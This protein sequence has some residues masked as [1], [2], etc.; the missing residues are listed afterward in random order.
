[1]KLPIVLKIKED[2]ILYSYLLR[3]SQ[4]NG[5]N[6]L[7]DF[8]G[9]TKILPLY[10][11]PKNAYRIVRYDIHNDLYPLLE[12]TEVSPTG[13]AELYR[14]TSLF[15]IVTLTCS[16]AISSHRIGMLSRYRGQA[17]L[18]TP[19]SDIFQELKFCPQCR[20]E[21]L[22]ETGE[23]YYRRSHQIPGVAVCHR[24]GCALHRYQ[25]ERES[26]LDPNQPSTEMNVQE[27]SREYAVLAHELLIADLSCDVESIAKAILSRMKEQGYSKQTTERLQKDM[28]AYAALLN[29]PLKSFFRY[30]PPK[31]Q[32]DMQTCHS[33][34]LFLF[35]DIKT[36]LAYLTKKSQLPGIEKQIDEK[37]ELMSPW[38]ENLLEFQCRSCH[39]CFLTTPHRLQ[40]GWGCP[41]CDAKQTDQE[42]FRHL[43]DTI[44]CG[45]Y[46]L[47][48][49]SSM[50]ESITIQHH[51]CNRV[52]SVRPR[53]FLEE[54]AR[55]ACGK[56]SSREE[57][58][59]RLAL[60]GDFELLNFQE[61]EKTLH[62][63]HKDCGLEFSANYSRFIRHPNCK[64]CEHLTKSEQDFQNEIYDLVGNEYKLVS[65]YLG[66]KIDVQIWHSV[67]G[68]VQTYK[69]HKFLSGSRCSKCHQ[70]LTYLDF[71]NI[72]KDVSFGIYT[73]DQQIGNYD[74]IIRNTQTGRSRKMPIVRVMQELFRFK[75]STILPLEKRNLKV[76]LTPMVSRRVMEWLLKN[77]HPGEP[78]SIR[79]INIPEMDPKQLSKTVQNLHRSKKIER[80]SYGI[81]MIPPEKEN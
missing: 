81:Y 53:V 70:R 32:C 30:F 37:Y 13:A 46:E 5:F 47:L 3:L 59:H 36:L 62:L 33:L 27:K 43:F 61:T 57:I 73:I 68:T 45:D 24:H 80:I 64:H 21:D 69:P 79:Q 67:C 76:S 25:G 16:K 12:V 1:M 66:R 58:E 55:C 65:P 50:K 20:E 44:A 22:A 51:A 63:L 15:P 54:S 48:S 31:S 2:E 41:V 78:F 7:R 39:H 14:K 23:W 8:L 77:F 35:G 49:F 60:L 29:A 72:V 11:N 18:I 34:I 42:L 19:L 10:E 71:C 56:A 40:G 75:P 28:G 52:Y 17:S 74:A 9:T 4:A 6:D 26:E 38:R